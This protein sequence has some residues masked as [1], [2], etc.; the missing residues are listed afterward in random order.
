MSESIAV[1]GHNL[2]CAGPTAKDIRRAENRT[3]LT[4]KD[5]H[6]VM[7]LTEEGMQRMV[8]FNMCQLYRIRHCHNIII[9]QNGIQ[10]H[11]ITSDY[12]KANRIKIT[13]L[14]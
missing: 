6:R 13:N 11:A 7:L 14:P 2:Q 3:V 1:F 8:T 9:Q 10:L 4:R 12:R 5:V